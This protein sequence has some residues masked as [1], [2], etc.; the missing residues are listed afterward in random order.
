[1]TERTLIIIKPD[2]IQRHL[3]GRIISRLEEKGFKLVAAKFIKIPEEVARKHYAVH[4]GKT[5]FE[6]LVK[7]LASSPSLVMVWQADGI[8]GYDAKN[9]RRNLRFR[10]RSR[11]HSRR[12]FLLQRLQSRPRLRHSPIRRKRDK[13]VLQTT[14]TC[15]LQIRR[16]GMA[17]WPKRLRIVRLLKKKHFSRI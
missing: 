9:A 3:A 8:I 7:H 6:G 2:G 4:K 16:R 15:R 10:C 1:M 5:F 13:P 17:V 14:G 11:N 12:F